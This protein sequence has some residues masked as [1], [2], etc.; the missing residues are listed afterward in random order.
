MNAPNVALFRFVQKNVGLPTNNVVKMFFILVIYLAIY[1]ILAIL[2]QYT[3]H[4]SV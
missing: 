2:N 1:F 3:K 4:I